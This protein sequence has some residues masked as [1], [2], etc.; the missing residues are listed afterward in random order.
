MSTEDTF[1]CTILVLQLVDMEVYRSGRGT[2]N[3]TIL[4]LQRFFPINYINSF[5]TFNCTILVLQRFTFIL[6]RMRVKSGTFNCTIL[7]LQL[8]IGDIFKQLI[9][10]FQLHYISITTNYRCKYNQSTYS[11]RLSIALY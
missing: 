2:F 10:H 5:A 11:Q 6:Q 9:N 8:V 7:V 1:N 4:V 3:C